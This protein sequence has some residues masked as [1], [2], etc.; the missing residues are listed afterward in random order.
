MGRISTGTVSSTGGAGG[1]YSFT[2]DVLAQGT[3]TGAG[4]QDTL[5]TSTGNEILRVRLIN[6]NA[7]TR[8]IRIWSNGVADANLIA[9]KDFPLLTGE[10]AI[11][12]IEL[13]DTDTVRAEASGADV[14]YTVEQEVIT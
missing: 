10:M 2:T 9:P 4:T 6:R 12:E 13:G 5:R 14:V 7:S 8:N 3:L 11:I 1:G